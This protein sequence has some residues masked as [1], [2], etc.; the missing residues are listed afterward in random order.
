MNEDVG[1]TCC[2]KVNPMYG[3]RKAIR[4][5]CPSGKR[6]TQNTKHIAIARGTPPP[7]PPKNPPFNFK[8][9]FKYF[10]YFYFNFYINFLL[11][12]VFYY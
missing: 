7:P 4:I 8:I 12:K 9:L 6:K 11:I 1:V 10:K 3:L 2:A 5:T